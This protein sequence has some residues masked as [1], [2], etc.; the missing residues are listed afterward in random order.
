MFEFDIDKDRVEEKKKKKQTLQAQFLENIKKNKERNQSRE[1]EEIIDWQVKYEEEKK[2]RKELQKKLKKQEKEKSAK[3]AKQQTLQQLLFKEKGKFSSVSK[4]L[5]EREQLTKMMKNEI[6]RFEDDHR[7]F[8][9]RQ[10]ELEQQVHKLTQEQKK[11]SF[12]K[13]ANQNQQLRVQL[14]EMRQK[15][16]K[17]QMKIALMNSIKRGEEQEQYKQE[18]RNLRERNKGLNEKIK[19][20][21]DVHQP[22]NL[23][24]V[25]K[26]MI[27]PE[28]IAFFY[29]NKQ[30]RLGKLSERIEELKREQER[31]KNNPPKA[32]LKLRETVKEEDLKMGYITK[33]DS[34]WYF[35]DIG[36]YE[37]ENYET[38]EVIGNTSN[39]KFKQDLPVKCILREDGTASVTEVYENHE[40]PEKITKAFKPKEKGEKKEKTYYEHFGKSKILI[41]GSRNLAEYEQ[42]LEKHGLIVEVHNPFEENY[43]RLEGKFNSADVV[44]VCTS[45]ISHAVMNH[46]DKKHPKVEMI[47]RDNEEWI[48]VRVKFAMQKLGILTAQEI[49]QTS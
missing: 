4:Q 32:W 20:Y 19:S 38:Y 16:K 34:T 44:V 15:M 49:M 42:R 6:K 9:N 8:I 23:L 31:K 22:D 40:I 17:I 33:H 3:T 12:D 43:H 7:Y 2:M 13:L 27:T 35:F 46:I 21:Q 14:E 1:K 10:K 24:T 30:N 48:A 26:D 29:Q 39:Q 28:N 5:K 11:Q 45:H 36:S 37:D 18:I 25:L 47:E 41:I